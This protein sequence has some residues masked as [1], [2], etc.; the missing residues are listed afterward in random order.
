MKSIL[1]KSFLSLYCMFSDSGGYSF[2]KIKYYR[3]V[4]RKMCLGLEH[5]FLEVQTF[6][7]YIRFTELKVLGRGAAVCLVCPPGDSDGGC[8]LGMSAVDYAFMC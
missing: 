3:P 1:C 4:I 7:H 2:I 6:R 8:S 5:Q